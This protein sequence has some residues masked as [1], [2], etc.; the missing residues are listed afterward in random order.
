M[1]ILGPPAVGLF[2]DALGLR[3]SLLRLACLGACAAMAALAVLGGA[4]HLAFGSVLAAV[5]AFAVF[6]SPIV[7]LADVVALERAR[8][9]GGAYGKVRLWGSVGFLVTTIA[10]GRAVD[11]RAAA[12]LPATIAAFLLLAVLAAWGLPPSPAAPRLPVAREAR[13]LLA[14][15]DFR[16]FLIVSMLAQ[17][18]H[19]GYDLC[20]SLHLRDM[21]VPSPHVGV[22]WAIGVVF[23]VVLMACAEPLLARFSAPGLVLFALIGAAAR[24]VLLA[25]VG[26]FAA[27]LALQPLHAISFGL[28]WIA[29]LAYVKERAPAQA[30]ATA[31]GLFSA[32]T[33][34]GSVV[35]MLAWGE[36][37]RRAAG[38]V[39]FGAAAVTALV[40]SLV[41]KAW[42]ESKTFAP[43][44]SPG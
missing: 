43:P 14:A 16:R 20:F 21:G 35:G 23:E 3:G 33:A 30:L 10:V 42:A 19:A 38:P 8:V 37:Y 36:T 7:M 5:L 2:A 32:A 9:A 4:G 28:W 44:A 31:Q 29:S 18:A 40:A 26:S 41:A 15:T 34:V 12:P 17:L 1:G 24:W 22:A 25:T 13:A 6:R 39:V 11:P 27:L